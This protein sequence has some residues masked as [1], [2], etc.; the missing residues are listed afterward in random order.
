MHYLTNLLFFDIS[1]VYYLINFNLSIT[2][3]IC[4]EHIY[5]SLGVF[6]SFSFLTVSE[7]FE[8]YVILLAHLLPNQI[9]TS[10]CFLFIFHYHTIILSFLWR[11]ISCLSLGISSLCSFLTV[12]KWF[13][14]ELLEVFLYLSAILL[15]IKAPVDSAIFWILFFQVVSYSS[16]KDYLTWSRNFWMHLPLRFLPIFL[17][18]DKNP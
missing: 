10:F 5:L 9:T 16:L 17:S 11:F 12:F 2:F 7:F 18:K 1:L 13:C 15:P 6:L 4:S 8:T 3:Y 14:C